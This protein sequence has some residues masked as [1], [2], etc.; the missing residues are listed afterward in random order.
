MWILILILIVL[1]AAA[2]VTYKTAEV[3]ELHKMR[4]AFED[5][6]ASI[7]ELIKQKKNDE[8]FNNDYY[9]GELEAID[10]VEAIIKEELDSVL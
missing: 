5:R 10:E 6:R 1:I 2:I 7:E 9:Q 8:N 3:H 4:A